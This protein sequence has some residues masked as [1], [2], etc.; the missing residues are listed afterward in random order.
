MLTHS[1]EL[2]WFFEGSPPD[3]VQRWFVGEAFRGSTERR[4]DQY[5]VL[6]GCNSV[7]IKLR[8]KTFEV[9]ALLD[10]AIVVVVDANVSG[11]ADTWIKWSTTVSAVSQLENGIKAD[12]EWADIEKTRWLS[13]FSLDNGAVEPVSTSSRPNEGCSAE[14]TTIAIAGAGWW[15]FA[16]EAFGSL[17]TIGSNLHRTAQQFFGTHPAPCPLPLAASCSYPAWLARCARP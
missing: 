11:L 12:A 15:S 1:A 13:K 8:K 9:K 7:G 16:L 10:P 3:D 14:F 6:P 17:A 5:L 4:T 2:R